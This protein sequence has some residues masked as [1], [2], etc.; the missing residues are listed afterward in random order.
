MLEH[1]PDPIET[2]KS[3]KGHLRLDGK[4]IIEVPNADDALLSLYKCVAFADFT[5]WVCHLYLFTN[6]TLKTV[7]ERAGLKIQFIQQIQRYPLS[8]HLKWLCDGVP[9][10]HQKWAAFNDTV[11][12]GLYGERLARLGIADTIMVVCG[13]D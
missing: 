9:G 5:Y 12:D 11:L 8:N 3:L 10:G 1:L 13:R 2:L 4:I 7:V 6:D